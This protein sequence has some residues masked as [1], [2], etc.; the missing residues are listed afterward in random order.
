MTAV[1]ET[2]RGDHGPFG[3]KMTG[4]GRGVGTFLGCGQT[5]TKQFP[6]TALTG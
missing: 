2:G 5:V 6:G 4:H 1:A 3:R